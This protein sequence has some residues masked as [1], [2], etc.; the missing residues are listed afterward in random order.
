MQHLRGDVKS[1]SV[2][3]TDLLYWYI[4][5][6]DLWSK[7]ICRICLKMICRPQMIVVWATVLHSSK[8]ILF[9]GKGARDF[10]HR[11]FNDQKSLCQGFGGSCW[12]PCNCREGILFWEEVAQLP[13]S[14]EE[15]PRCTTK[16]FAGELC[17]LYDSQMLMM[18]LPS[19]MLVLRKALAIA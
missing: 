2:S 4:V 9:P 15:S 11:W 7:K 13:V 16:G 18:L 6:D 3:P 19:L 5:L 17:R 12:S 14:W 10:G 8:M 1:Q